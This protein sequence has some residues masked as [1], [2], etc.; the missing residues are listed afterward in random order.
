[1]NYHLIP[2]NIL[3]ANVT[4]HRPDHSTYSEVD[5]DDPALQVM[6]DFKKVTAITI[7]PWGVDRDREPKDDPEGYTHAFCR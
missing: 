7:S 3:D 4:Y 6:T 2:S 1:M 5:M